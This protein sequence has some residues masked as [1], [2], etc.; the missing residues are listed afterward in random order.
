M[1]MLANEYVE[2]R[3]GGYY[4]SGTRIGLDVVAHDFMRGCSAEAIFDKYPSVGSLAKVYGAV[5]FMLDH[6]EEVNAYLKEQGRIF[7]QFKSDH[8]VPAEMK[9]RF[10]RARNARSVETTI[11]GRR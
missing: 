9:E 11:P 7:E 3:N 5:A 4:L 10:E 2:I 6:P 1:T 8:P